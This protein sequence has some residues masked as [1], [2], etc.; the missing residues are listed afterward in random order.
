MRGAPLSPDANH[1]PGSLGHG[2]EDAL[3]REVVG[4]VQLACALTLGMAGRWA[5]HQMDLVMGGSGF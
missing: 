3:M 5:V 1:R 4:F 2:V